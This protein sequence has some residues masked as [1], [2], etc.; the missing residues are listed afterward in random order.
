MS[1][2]HA[3]VI[4]AGFGGLASALR[5]RARGYRV[6]VLEALEQAG[7]RGSV[8]ERD[9]YT[10]DAGPTVITAP[11]LI[12]ELF[13]LHGRDPRDYVELVPVDPY[14]R[15]HFDDGG[16][17]DYVGDEER[18]LEQ[19]AELSP[20]DVE[21][22]KRLAEHAHRIFDVGYAEL[23]DVPFDRLETMLKAVPDLL[24]LENYRS[25]AGLVAKYIQ[26]PRLRQVFSFHTL[27]VGGNPYATTSIYLLI[28]WLERKWG[29]HYALG[30]TGS[31]VRGLVRL[32][33]EL[34]VEVRLNSPVDRVLVEGRRAV[35]VQVGEERLLG[36]LVVANADPSMVYTKLIRPEELRWNGPTRVRLTSQSMSLF[37]LYFGTTR[38]YDEVA[39]HSIVLGPRYEALLTDIFDKKVLAE[40][41]SLYLHRPTASDPS[42]A[43]EG[44]DA[45]YVLSPVPNLEGGQDWEEL[46]EGYTQAV[47]E[48]LEE[49][50][51][52]GLREHLGPCFSVD[53]RYFAERLRSASGA[54]FGPEPIFRQSAFFRFH[55]KSPDL[56]GLYFVGAG[57]HPGA[58]V[59]GVLCS[60]KVLERLLDERPS[61][62]A[63]G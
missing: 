20:P 22:Y 32:L 31:V 10:F 14:Y 50:L 19:I 7:G 54:A 25:V 44:C 58:G 37:V 57:T 43:P 15:V 23:A 27:L 51:L 33:E 4:G 30:G 53:P 48:R 62:S 55:N 38:R 41:F 63:A 6:T 42:M 8:F 9:G 61:A 47:L 39:H 56:E 2:P 13:E 36:E 18:I 60:A 35:G 24:R 46:V 28:H 12:D 1:E 3:I 11:Y 29:V 16:H 5:L 17:F 34:G 52:P 40:D 21:G 59:P 45:W 49:R 26:D